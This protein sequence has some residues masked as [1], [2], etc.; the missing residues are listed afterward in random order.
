MANS[1]KYQ[2][3]PGMRLFWCSLIATISAFFFMFLA[4]CSPFWYQSWRRVH[5][6]LANVGLWH[7]CLS[8]Y[9][10]P[11]D[12]SLQSYVGCWWIHSTFFKD[13]D[14]FIMPPWFRACQAL[15]CFEFLCFLASL[16]LCV[17]YLVGK[18]RNAI[19][20]DRERD[21]GRLVMMHIINAVLLFAGSFLVFIVS[22]VF[23]EMAR[24]EDYFPRPWM[25]YLSWSYGSNVLAGFFSA[26]GGICLFIRAMIIKEK[27]FNEDDVDYQKRELGTESESGHT[28]MMSVK[29]KGESEV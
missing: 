13:V 22:L 10:K 14:N 16:F 24:Q 19:Y 27:L 5:S 28:G 4:F 9:V 8:G 11:K 1:V 15:V 2:I 18:W 29:S 23:A 17:C 12:P 25:N 3:N 21:Q 7:I 20:K 6:P 26:F